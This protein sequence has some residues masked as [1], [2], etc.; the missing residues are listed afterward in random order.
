MGRDIRYNKYHKHPPV[1]YAKSWRSVTTRLPMSETV[2]ASQIAARLTPVVA[3]FKKD[4]ETVYLHTID[5]EVVISLTTVVNF[6]L[7]WFA[8][9]YNPIDST[10]TARIESDQPK[11]CKVCN[12]PYPIVE[13]PH[14]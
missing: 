6:A 7:E 3:Q 10:P 2:I 14:R 5:T 13:K 4:A 9:N 1:T 8:D 11:R 12:H